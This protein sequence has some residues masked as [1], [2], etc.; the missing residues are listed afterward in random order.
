MQLKHPTLTVVPRF[1]VGTGV[2][3]LQ[4]GVKAVRL[5]YKKALERP[6]FTASLVSE[7]GAVLESHD[8]LPGTYDRGS[9]MVQLNVAVDLTTVVTDVPERAPRKPCSVPSSIP[10]LRK[11]CSVPSSIPLLREPGTLDTSVTAIQGVSE[12]AALA[13]GGK[14]GLMVI[15][16]QGLGCVLAAVTRAQ[17]RLGALFDPCHLPGDAGSKLIVELKH[18]KEKERKMSVLAWSFIPTSS[19]I[20]RC[21]RPQGQCECFQHLVGVQRGV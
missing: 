18:Y 2:G 20:L 13:D 1:S 6:F 14:C 11:P 8:S 16:L 4:I 10:L 5:P 9:Q 15:S 21:C 7:N 19:F 17:R 3:R 12:G